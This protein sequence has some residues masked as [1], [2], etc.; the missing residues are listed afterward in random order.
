MEEKELHIETES[1]NLAEAE[2]LDELNEL[3]GTLE[4]AETLLEELDEEADLEEVEKTK[5]KIL[6]IAGAAIGLAI[7][8][9]LAV[10]L[11]RKKN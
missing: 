6:I 2:A 7:A 11:T 8:A 10:I 1:E 9:A 4:D 3:D 5:K